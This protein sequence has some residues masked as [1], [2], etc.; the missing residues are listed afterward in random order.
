MYSTQS[1]DKTTAKLAV[2]AFG[3]LA[4]LPPSSHAQTSTGQTGTTCSQSGLEMTCTTVVKYTMPS[5]VAL[6]SGAV[7]AGNFVLNATTGGP[8]CGPIT[9]SPTTVTSGVAT[10]IALTITGCVSGTTYAWQ[11]PAV[12]GQ[13]ANTASHTSLTLTGNSATQTYSV[14]ACAP[15]GV[16]PCQTYTTTVGVTQAIPALSSCAVTPSAPTIDTSGSTTLSVSCATGAGVGSGV[17]WQW[18]KDGQNVAG[19][20]SATHTV[21]GSIGQ[22]TYSYTVALTNNAPSTLTS[23][24][25]TVTVTPPITSS[26][27]PGVAVPSRTITAGDGYS[28]W[29]S[30]GHPGNT[31]YVVAIDVPATASSLP[32]TQAVI[33]FSPKSGPGAREYTISRSP[34]DFAVPVPSYGYNAVNLS[35]DSNILPSPHG[36]YL[37]PGRWYLNLR[38]TA[39]SATTTCSMNMQAQP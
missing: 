5:G 33:N 4:W 8:G 15:S 25:S 10:A 1:R 37:A 24:A 34:C 19:A 6:Q 20:N 18:R 14:E 28:T 32:D 23:T 3:L 21:L 26:C 39:C 38:S 16:N 11:S 13:P 12:Q 2:I 9:A 30:T 7:G 29:Y 35:Y 31:P 17:T 36:Y 22:G 27:P